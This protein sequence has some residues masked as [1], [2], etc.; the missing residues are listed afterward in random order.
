MRFRAERRRR[1][2]APGLS[3]SPPSLQSRFASRGGPFA[4]AY[5]V[6]HEYGHR[7]QEANGRL[8]PDSFPHGTFARNA[9]AGSPIG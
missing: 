9:D 8:G 5:V 6:A 1:E 3:R 2:H 7:I 4:E